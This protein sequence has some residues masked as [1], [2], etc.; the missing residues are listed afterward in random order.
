MDD[1]IG[2]STEAVLEVVAGQRDKALTDLAISQAACRQ[3]AARVREL[4]SAREEATDG[5]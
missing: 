4:E 5:A 3:L 2:V 1:R